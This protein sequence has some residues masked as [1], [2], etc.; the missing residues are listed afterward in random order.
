VSA[1]RVLLIANRGDEDSGYVGDALREHGAELVTV[2][3]EDPNP[4]PGPVGFDAVVSL[5]S[6]WSV[7]WPQVAAQVGREEDL[8]RSAVGAGVPV[9]GIC[10]GGQILA[11]ALGGT[12][13]RAPTAEIGWFEV[14]SDVPVLL[15]PGPYV[16]WHSDRFVPPPGSTELARSPAGSQAFVLGAALGL[17]FHPEATPA[18]VRRWVQEMPADLPDRLD[19]EAFAAQS[20]ARDGEAGQRARTIVDTFLSGALA[21]HARALSG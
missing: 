14:E 12:V 20:D 13:T 17:Q 8:L 21:D 2:L 9:L 1:V 18:V 7:Y 15:P 10:F 6:E 4:L 5:G 19:G 3:R 16:Q 11:H